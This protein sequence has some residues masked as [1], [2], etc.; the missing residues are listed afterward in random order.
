MVR[1]GNRGGYEPGEG[2]SIEEAQN[3]ALRELG[4]NLTKFRDRTA[5]RVDEFGVHEELFVRNTAERL[6]A[7]LPDPAVP[8]VLDRV[9]I[10]VGD[11]G[12]S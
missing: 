6:I 3:R 12:F 9:G 7:G 1:L 4:Q 8:E 2:V 5:F 10:E 11:S